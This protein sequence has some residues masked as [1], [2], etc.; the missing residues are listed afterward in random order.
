MIALKEIK[1]LRKQL[2]L[3]QSDLAKLSGVSQSLIAK[4]ESELIDPAYSKAV[5]VTSALEQLSQK[6]ELQAK[7]VMAKKV[8]FIDSEDSLKLAVQKMRTHNFSQL[9]VFKEKVPIGLITEKDVVN[10]LLS[11]KP[12]D[13]NVSEVMEECPPIVSPQIQISLLSG[14][15]KYTNMVLV[16]DKEKIIGLVT[17]SDLLKTF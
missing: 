11:D 12:H 10:I 7:D 1:K 14:L 5:A 6:K 13:I 15:L 8:T 17:R 3:T 16:K 9:P 4:I 2:N